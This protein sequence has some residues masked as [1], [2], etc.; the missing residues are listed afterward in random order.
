[1]GRA[2]EAVRTLDLPRLFAYFGVEADLQRVEASR[3]AIAAR[4]DA[5]VRE[6]VRLCP[7]LRER[8]R[9]TVLR[10]ALRLAYEVGT[11]TAEGAGAAR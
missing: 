8:E 9:F 3:P 7:A 2:L 1:M 10:E 4:F 6:L 11:R 5:E